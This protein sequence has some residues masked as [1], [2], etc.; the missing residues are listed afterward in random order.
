MSETSKDRRAARMPI[1]SAVLMIR[2]D[3]SW[4]SEVED[5]SATGVRITRPADWMGQSGDLFVLDMLFG[6]DLNI[7]LDARV[8]RVSDDAIGF[9]F[10]RIPADKEIPL[11]SLLGRHADEQEHWR[12]RR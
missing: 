5:I 2:G 8:A 3:Q 9:V 4:T 12:N 10:S 1:Y 11:W 6:Q 7:H